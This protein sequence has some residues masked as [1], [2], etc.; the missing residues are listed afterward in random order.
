MQS[1]SGGLSTDM[2]N[3][4]MAG[5]SAEMSA[6]GNVSKDD[7]TTTQSAV[8]QNINLDVRNGEIPTALLYYPSPPFFLRKM[9]L[10]PHAEE[11]K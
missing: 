4:A 11:E 8:S 2:G 3:L 5:M 1:V 9:V 10:P 7:S 6:L